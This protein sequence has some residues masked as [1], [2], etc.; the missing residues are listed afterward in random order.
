MRP[1]NVTLLRL[2]SERCWRFSNAP[3]QDSN[4]RALL[5]LI[6]RIFTAQQ[7][8]S[9]AGAYQAH[10]YSTAISER[11]WGLSSA[12]LQDS[13]FRALLRLIKRIFTGQKISERCWHLSS[14]SLAAVHLKKRCP[15]LHNELSISSLIPWYENI[16]IF[17]VLFTLSISP[18]D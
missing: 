3:L 14:A 2:F 18:I 12:S 16:T 17:N 6:K 11:C 10:L 15:H 9:A 7:L 5:G 4:F 1:P 13:N 8:E